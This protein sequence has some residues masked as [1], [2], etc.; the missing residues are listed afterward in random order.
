MILKRLK[1]Q[2]IRSYENFEVLFNKGS[3]LLAGDI[4]SGKTSILLAIEFALFGLQPGQKGASLL[5]N[6]QDEGFVELE[7][8]VD[9]NNIII[10][11]N[12]K[13]KKT[14][15]QDSSSIEI[16]GKTEEKA[17]TELKNIISSS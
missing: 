15:S 1:V 3:T 12:L 2:N 8:E 7:F 14:I 5:R 16:N 11:R 6:G 10:N 13:R 4:G 17:V 9:G